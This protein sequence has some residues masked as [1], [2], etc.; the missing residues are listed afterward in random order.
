MNEKKY[1]IVQRRNYY[2]GTLNARGD[3]WHRIIS[4]LTG[5]PVV[6]DSRD[7]A[8]QMIAKMDAADYELA[9]SEYSRPSYRIVRT[10]SR[11]WHD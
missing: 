6:C 2:E 7:D 10:D 3:H 4:D 8:R 11:L 9:H 5:E 1:G